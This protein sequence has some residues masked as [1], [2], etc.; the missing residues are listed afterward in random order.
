MAEVLDALLPVV[1]SYCD[2]T[3]VLS[4]AA[5]ARHWCQAARSDQVWIQCSRSRWHFGAL[6][7]VADAAPGA[8]DEASLRLWQ[9]SVEEYRAGVAHANAFGF[10]LSR[11][12]QDKEV[13][14]LLHK[15]VAQEEQEQILG[16]MHRLGA[17]VLDILLKLEQEEDMRLKSL[18]NSAR[19]Q[20]TNRWAEQR[21]A[22]LLTS[23]AAT[24]LEEGAF[25]L[26]QWGYPNADVSAMRSSLERLAL[27][28]AELGAR[29]QSTA[30]PSQAEVRS[31]VLAINQ[32]LYQEFGL[33]GNQM[34]Y[35]NP[36]NSMLHAVLEKKKGI[37]ISLSVVWAAVARRC[38]LM[39]HSLAN[40]PR[41]VLI[42]IPAGGEGPAENNDLYL[43]AFDNGKLMSWGEFCSFLTDMLAM[44]GA[45]MRD[46]EPHLSEFVATT[47]PVLLYLRMMRNLE[48][49]YGQTG[50]QLRLEGI[51]QQMQTLIRLVE[52]P[53]P[54]S[55][56]RQQT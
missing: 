40:V 6:F 47:T 28:A 30:L 38:G 39:C 51:Q 13:C 43:D 23:E 5:V 44:M 12:K 4:M 45:R 37:P 16:Q 29:R 21:W 15:A 25:I 35:Y 14:Q 18:A 2:V 53:A 54:A 49:I 20:I 36:E 27:R 41:H 22:Q 33:E 1:C 10:F 52:H 19:V 32:A 17:N 48:N 50:D 3:G 24:T 31:M 46:I 8:R 34:D 42:R 55:G 11:S 7:Q 26:S 56:Y 9:R